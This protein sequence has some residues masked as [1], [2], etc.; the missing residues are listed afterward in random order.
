MIKELT[1]YIATQASRTIGTNLYAGPWPQDAPETC[2]A[3]FE[4]PGGTPDPNVIGRGER[5]IQVVS[6]GPDYIAARDEAFAMRAV[7]R[8]LGRV[9]LPVVTSGETWVVESMYP[10]GDP[11]YIGADDK[12]RQEFSTNCRL[13]VIEPD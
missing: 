3:V 11:G 5:F 8:I 4:R 6:R 10:I 1:T 2:S 12:G 7:F 9:T 13:H